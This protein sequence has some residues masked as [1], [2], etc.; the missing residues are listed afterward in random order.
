M[1]TSSRTSGRK[2]NQKI[3]RM[4]LLAM[5]SA[6][7]VLLG[8][9]PLGLIPITPLMK[10]TTLHIPVIIGAILLGPA[11]GAI[12][13]G[14]FGI[15]SFISNSFLSPGITSFVFT[16]LQVLPGTDHGSLLSLLICFVPRILIGVTAGYTFRLIS[17]FDKSKI[18]ACAAAGVVGSV[19][20]TALVFGGIALF[21][22]PEYAAAKGDV[23]LAAIMGMIVTY[24]IPETIVA[25]VLAALIC[26]SLFVFMDK[27]R[28]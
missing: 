26:K 2:S 20:N 18:G 6:I 25:A 7:I 23:L 3:R 16:P 11:D 9:T 4:V 14:V 19:V 10:A 13:G 27:R 21:F 17:R 12:L 22:G 1:T 24:G 28:S 8:I 15:M 5:F